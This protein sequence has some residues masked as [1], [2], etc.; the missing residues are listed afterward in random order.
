MPRDSI[1]TLWR[2]PKEIIISVDKVFSHNGGSM[3]ISQG[4]IEKAMSQAI[5]NDREYIFS[6]L[7][8]DW[9]S[10]NKMLVSDFVRMTG[11]KQMTAYQWSWDSTPRDPKFIDF[12]CKLWDCSIEY[13]FFG[14]GMEKTE[15]DR[16]LEE[17]EKSTQ[18]KDQDIFLMAAEI[19]QQQFL[20]A[21]MKLQN[22][23]LVNELMR[24][25]LK[26]KDIDRALEAQRQEVA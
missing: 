6:A 19:E 7:F 8:R 24:K 23:Y 16:L 13:M 1:C 20:F 21:D 12:F 5:E 10:R 25:G 4:E 15:K 2:N 17:S 26:R 11:I 14:E 3:R 9:L 18:K 22:E